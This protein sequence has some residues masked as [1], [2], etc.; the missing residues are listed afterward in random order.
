[1]LDIRTV[2]NFKEVTINFSF[3]FAMRNT[4]HTSFKTLL[5][6]VVHRPLPVG[7]LFITGSQIVGKLV[8]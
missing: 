4:V 2:E 8:E 3:I 7:Q 5:L 6:S 1:M